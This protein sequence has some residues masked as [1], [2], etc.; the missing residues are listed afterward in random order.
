MSHEAGSEPQY[1]SAA[2]K[3][4]FALRHLD[5]AREDA[6]EKGRARI[7]KKEL[8]R[9]RSQHQNILEQEKILTP[10]QKAAEIEAQTGRPRFLQNG[11][12]TSGSGPRTSRRDP[13]RLGDIVSNL[14]RSRKWDRPLLA[15]RIVAE[16]GEVAGEAIAKNTKATRFEDGVLYVQA[17]SSM[18]AGQLRLLLPQILKK[19]AETYGK[20][21][22][23]KVI[24]S[25]PA[26]R[27]WKHGPL[28][29][30]G[31]GPRDTYG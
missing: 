21:V 27:S 7:T 2:A 3:R 26:Q 16:W 4:A 18:W 5:K 14:V 13:A 17:S 29:V 22:V 28:S 31:R 11:F 9:R 10:A 1:L 20:D 30:P 6:W 12:D 23:Q 25:G 24:V 19:L 15:G 8:L